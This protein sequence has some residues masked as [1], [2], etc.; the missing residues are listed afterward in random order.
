MDP[1]LRST[2]LKVTLPAVIAVAV[3]VVAKMRGIAWDAELGLRRSSLRAV[4]V[5][6]VLWVAWIAIGEWIIRAAGLEPPKA[7]PAYPLP[8]VVLRVLAIGLIGP[9]SE[10]LVVRGLLLSRLR[11][12]RLGTAGAVVVTAVGW[13]AMHYQYSP[14]LIAMI[15]GDGILL[16]AARVKGRSLWIPVALHALGNLFSIYQSMTG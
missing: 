9:F 16:G 4:A 7:W 5:W 15:A 8:I 3:F 13:A 1:L 11:R 2:L 14:G 12:T 6:I 10:E